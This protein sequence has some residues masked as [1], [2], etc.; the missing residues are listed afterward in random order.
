METE[1]VRSGRSGRSDRSSRSRT[2][3]SG[4][5]DRQ[6]KKNHGHSDRRSSRDKERSGRSTDRDTDRETDREDRSVSACMPH[7]DSD[8][9]RN[10]VHNELMG[11][12]LPPDENWGETTTVI[13][14]TTSEAGYSVEEMSTSLRLN[15]KLE[16][17]IGFHCARYIGSL[18]T[19]LM[20]VIAFLSPVVM[21]I[22]P[23]VNLDGWTVN[24]CKPECEGLLISFGFKLIILL[25]GSWALFL[26]RPKSTMPRIFIFRAVVLLLVFVLTVAYW[27]F[28]GVRIL[29]THDE[30]YPGIVAFS[31]SMVDCLLFHSLSCRHPA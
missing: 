21:V 23:K 7:T 8:G 15:K 24:E 5:Q 26:R 30:N 6:S 25:I 31:V 4:D 12:S 18:T 27:L 17:S 13:T 20:A 16:N 3:R 2:E 19:G 22:L 10:N 9:G 29:A 14:G 11:G 28:Y 1:S